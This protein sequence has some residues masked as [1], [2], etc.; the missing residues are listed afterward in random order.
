MITNIQL[1]FQRHYKWLFGILLVIVAVSFIFAYGPAAS[2]S[3]KDMVKRPGQESTFFGYDLSRREVVD[4]LAR[5]TVVGLWLKTG[6][7]PL[8]PES[9]QTLI[10]ERIIEENIANRLGVPTPSQDNLTGYIATLPVFL[11]EQGNFSKKR[12]EEFKGKVAADFGVDEAFLGKQIVLRWRLDQVADT[13]ERSAFI[14]DE[15]LQREYA[16]VQ[17]RYEIVL[18]TLEGDEEPSSAPTKEEVQAYYD[19]F[20]NNYRSPELRSGVYYHL[21]NESFLSQ[22]PEP[23]DEQLEK[24]FDK[25]ALRFVQWQVTDENGKVTGGEPKAPVFA[26][27]K[28]ETRQLYKQAKAT[29]AA[30]EAIDA[31][32]QKIYT[33]ELQ[34]DTAQWNELITASGVEVTKITDLAQD[35]TPEG[36][37]KKAVDVLFTRELPGRSYSEAF[38][39]E[40]EGGFVLLTNVEPSG[41]LSLDEATKQGLIEDATANKTKKEFQEKIPGILV[42][43]L[44]FKDADAF[45]AAAK[46]KGFEVSRPELFTLSKPSRQINSR[47]LLADLSHTP[48][49]EVAQYTGDFNAQIAYVVMREVPQFDE[50][51][52]EAAK[53]KQTIERAYKRM[54]MVSMLDEFSQK[55]GMKK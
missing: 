22:V 7:P 27:H 26:E 25:I 16:L 24:Y 29:R 49:G 37:A 34:P 42:D 4:Q 45:E 17:T 20:A 36:V 28:E 44:S 21:S 1:F 35:Q 38:M 43:M 11:D 9:L 8:N 55:N 51:N 53:L 23:T 52:P 19:Q 13:M 15:N 50:A 31:I 48:V 39:G 32:V 30:A 14:L 6:M 3:A 5:E 40:D 12:F 18:G 10:L 2:M 46:E 33:D 54:N 47:D 41:V